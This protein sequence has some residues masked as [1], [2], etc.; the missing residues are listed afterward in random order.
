MCDESASRAAATASRMM[1]GMI[2]TC[3]CG[4]VCD[5][6]GRGLHDERKRWEREVHARRQERNRKTAWSAASR[7]AF[8][9]VSREPEHR[10]ARAAGHVPGQRDVLIREYRVAGD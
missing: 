1:V 10:D 8:G 2:N 6:G 5:A 3:L 9:A 7:H 4:C